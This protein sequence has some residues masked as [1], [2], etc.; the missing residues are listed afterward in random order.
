MRR[1]GAVISADFVTPRDKLVIVLTV[2]GRTRDDLTDPNAIL[3]GVTLE[4][5]K[6]GTP[7]PPSLKIGTITKSP[8][9]VNIT[10][11]SVASTTYVLE[12]KAALSDPAWQAGAQIT[13]TGTSTTLTDSTAAHLSGAQGFWRI[14]SQ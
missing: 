13:A 6:G 9:G 12:Y 8:N 11:P 2:N 3:D 7:P 4:I 5:L 1:A 14:R 10:F